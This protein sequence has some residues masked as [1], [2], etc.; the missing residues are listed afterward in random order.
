MKSLTFPFA[1]SARAFPFAV[2]ISTATI[3]PGCFL[4]P[5]P[6]MRTAA[7][8]AR[9]IEPRCRGIVDASLVIDSVAPAYSY[10]SGGPVGRDAHMR[11]AE[12]HLRPGPGLTKEGIQRALECHEALATL[13]RLQA[14]P[15]DPYFLPDV[16]LEINADSE[17]DGFVVRVLVDALDDARNVLAR[18]RRTAAANKP[19]T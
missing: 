14:I 15:D 9:E 1:S 4:S 13:G 3:A 8:H 16:W 2:V 5:I 11:G 17:G 12:I 10:I 7:D 6:D 18:A 19:K